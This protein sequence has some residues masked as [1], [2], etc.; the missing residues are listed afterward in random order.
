LQVDGWRFEPSPLHHKPWLN[1][2]SC[3]IAPASMSDMPVCVRCSASFPS[4]LILDG[5]VRFTHRRKLCLECSP[6]G[7]HNTR[8]DKVGD[9]ELTCGACGKRYDYRRS[10]GR[11]SK[12]CPTCFVRERR[13]RIKRECIAI[14]GGRCLL[15][16]YARSEAAL[17]FHHLDP[18]E[19]EFAISGSLRA[20]KRVLAEIDKCVL[21][22]K[23]CHAEIHAGVTLLPQQL[24]EEMDGSSPLDNS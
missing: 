1:G 17:D 12:R 13:Q 10:F 22:C 23:N 18:S 19:K 2:S 24:R 6:F 8:I 16:G 4:R 14:K 15:C 21:L 9:R 7:L 20:R 11:S 3:S 5:I